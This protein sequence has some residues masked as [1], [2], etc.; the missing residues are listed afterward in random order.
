MTIRLWQLVYQN[1]WTSGERTD[2]AF[3]RFDYGFHF[4]LYCDTYLIPKKKKNKKQ[5]LNKF[6]NIKMI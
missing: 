3:N 5:K 4:E 6:N 2:N 1:V